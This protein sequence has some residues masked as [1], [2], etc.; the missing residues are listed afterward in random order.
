LVAAAPHPANIDG[1]VPADKIAAAA[2]NITN[3]YA[4]KFEELYNAVIK[5]GTAYA[6]KN[7][8]PVKQVNPS[9]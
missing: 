7:R 8:I 1:N 9:P 2:K 4:A 5:I 3:K 6:E